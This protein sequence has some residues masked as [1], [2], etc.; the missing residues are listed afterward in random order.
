MVNGKTTLMESVLVMLLCGAEES[1]T[2]TVNVNVPVAVGVP[3]KIPF[4]S[5]MPAG[6]TPEYKLQV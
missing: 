6:K 2:W 5:V 4:D 1:L 3:D